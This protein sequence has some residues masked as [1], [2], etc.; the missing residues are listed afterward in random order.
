MRTQIEH[1]LHLTAFDSYGTTEIMGPGVAFECEHHDGLHVSEDH[2]IVEVV[3]PHSGAPRGAGEEGELVFTTV[4]KQ[5][6]PLIRYRTGDI[7]SC[8]YE[9]CRCGRTLARMSRVSGRSDDMIVVEGRSIFPSEIEQVLLE[10]EGV[11]PH[12]MII[13]D[14]QGGVDTVEIKLEI[15]RQLPF[16]DDYGKL[17]SFRAAIRGAIEK[18]IG[19]AARVTFVEHQTIARS[20]GGT[21]KRVEDR[22][23]M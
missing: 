4:T 23:A 14:R 13:L 19:L 11:E 7:S 1:G 21:M 12:Y 17:E 22:R 10:V 8:I 6:F 5:G 16:V 2:F 20:T 15:P 3:D 9:P 18:R